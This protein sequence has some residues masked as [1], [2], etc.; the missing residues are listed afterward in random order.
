MPLHWYALRSKPRKEDVVWRQA[1]DQGFELFYPRLKVHTVNPRARQIRPYFPG[2]LFVRA[3]IETVGLSV[4]QWMPHA[5]GL[6]TFGGEPATVPDNLIAAIRQRVEEIAASG[7]E[8]FDGLKQG[9]KVMIQFGPFEGYEAIF[10]ARIPGT[11]RVRVL[12]QLL[13]NQRHMPVELDASHI[14]RKK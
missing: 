5:S 9:D 14:K 11:E 13:S 8:V 1:R 12:L 4:F 3:D 10:D 7:G 2:Y 6:V